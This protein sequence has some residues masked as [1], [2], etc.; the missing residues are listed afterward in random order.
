VTIHM[1]KNAEALEAALPSD[2]HS[3]VII[4]NGKT[5]F[6]GQKTLTCAAF[7]LFETFRKDSALP[8]ES[9]RVELARQYFVISDEHGVD[10]PSV[11]EI[12]IRS[13]LED[14][15]SAMHH[16][17]NGDCELHMTPNTARGDWLAGAFTKICLRVD[18][19]VL[20]QSKADQLVELG[21]KVTHAQVGQF[22]GFCVE[23]SYSSD[24][25]PALDDL[26]P[27]MGW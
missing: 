10:K 14:L 20:L 4:D 5:H 11:C 19:D 15:F 3:A 26:R 16:K 24:I 25:R 6:N 8:E 9:E 27:L 22:K 12:T 1:V 17:E 7:G 18:T 21:F 13:C 23:P 2:Q